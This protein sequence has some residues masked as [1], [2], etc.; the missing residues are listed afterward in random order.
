MR[1]AMYRTRVSCF[2]GG[3]H[4][5]IAQLDPYATHRNV[6]RTLHSE[7]HVFLLQEGA[8]SIMH[9]D[10]LTKDSSA[11]GFLATITLAVDP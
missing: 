6:H 4:C 11:G 1:A 10:R 7:D 9:L 8:Q 5:K 3:D 2:L